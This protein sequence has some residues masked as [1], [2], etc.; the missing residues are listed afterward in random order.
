MTPVALITGSSRGIGRG[1]ALELANGGTHDL[2]INY[3]GNES[4][5]LECKKLCDTAAAGKVRVEIVQADVSV[6]A[7]R[8]RMVQFVRQTFG[9][10]DL[11]VNNAGVAPN[12]RADL[13]D[14]GEESFD[15]LI[16]INLKGP[17]F[18]T[19]AA[20]KLMIG[21]P[22]IPNATRAVVNVT[23]ISAFTVSVNRGDYC[24]AK[25]GLAMMTKLYAVR[26]AEH[27]IGV[28]E[29]QPGVIETDMTGAVKEKYDKL[30]AEGLAPINRWGQPSDI[31]K[32]V[33]AVAT[34]LF[35]YSTG[36]VFNV[37]GGF[38]LRTL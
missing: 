25:A 1:I 29:I 6:A 27:G 24:I 16:S 34:G 5:A 12:V 20:T 38:H 26:L 30:F 31:G 33:V 13:L 9:R 7:D 22:K 11:L 18:L 36:Q 23:S 15:R 32:C 3:A 17:Y 8:E 35:P 21:S 4:A 37:D 28:F 10:L 14:A 19:Q 2:V